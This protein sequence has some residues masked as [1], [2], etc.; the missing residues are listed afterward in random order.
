MAHLVHFIEFLYKFSPL[1]TPLEPPLFNFSRFSPFILHSLCISTVYGELTPFFPSFCLHKYISD[2]YRA[3]QYHTRLFCITKF[4]SNFLYLLELFVPLSGTF[5]TSQWENWF[6]LME[7]LR[8]FCCSRIFQ[9]LCL[10]QTNPGT[11]EEL[12]ARQGA[13]W[14]LV[15]NQ[16]ELGGQLMEENYHHYGGVGYCG[17]GGVNDRHPVIIGESRL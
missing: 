11:H 13:Y 16:L 14:Y 9:Y 6:Q 12:I 1:P 10:R 2:I 17:F 3:T 15:K 7:L 4:S 8:T 5:C